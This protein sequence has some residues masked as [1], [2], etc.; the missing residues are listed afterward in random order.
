MKLK[1]VRKYKHI[2]LQLLK[3][4]SAH[5]RHT[6]IKKIL[7]FQW[8]ASCFSPHVHHHAWNESYTVYSFGGTV[9]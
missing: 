8:I 4:F 9:G 3:F 6:E 1:T 2:D 5:P 7:K